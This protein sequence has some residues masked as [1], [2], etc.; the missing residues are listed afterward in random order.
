[1]QTTFTTMFTFTTRSLKLHKTSGKLTH[2]LK[3]FLQPTLGDLNYYKGKTN[4]MLIEQHGIYRHA[5]AEMNN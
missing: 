3:L 2:A 5:C 1:M 4:A